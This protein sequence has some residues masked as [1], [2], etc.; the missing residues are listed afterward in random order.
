MNS[1][2]PTLDI[3]EFIFPINSRDIFK[4]NKDTVLE[5]GFGEGEFLV[6][7]A[8]KNDDWNFLGIEIKSHRF[9][10]AVKHSKYNNLSNI[11]L[12]HIEAEVALKQVFD[13]NIF[14]AVYIN[15]PD[16]WPKKKHVKHRI[17][18]QDFIKN[19]AKVLKTGGRVNIKTDYHDYI[20]Q[21]NNEFSKNKRFNN[22]YG[23]NGYIMDTT[24]IV[25]TKFEKEFKEIGKEIFITAFTN[26]SN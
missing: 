11:K 13:K 1:V 21:I 16:P 26:L 20:K 25:Q 17:F 2:D 10:K 18:H 14:N 23:I 8:L 3:S 7:L 12:L 19:L 5:I 9:K 22:I 6:D 15:F 4:N 24:N